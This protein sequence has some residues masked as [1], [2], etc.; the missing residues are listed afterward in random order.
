MSMTAEISSEEARRLASQCLGNSYDESI[1]RQFAA[2]LLPDAERLSDGHITGKYIPESFQDYVVSYRRLA[3]MPDAGK[4]KLDVLAVKLKNSSQLM[5]ARSMQRQFIARYLNG[6]RD[7]FKDA[8][9]VAFHSDDSP[10]WRFSFVYKDRVFI[11]GKVESVLSEP[12]RASFMVGPHELTH[13]AERQFVDLLQAQD[14]STISR[15]REAFGVERVTREFFNEYRQLFLEL[16]DII[17]QNIDDDVKVCKEF[18]SRDISAQ[19]YAKRMLG[20][21]VFLYFLQKKGW[22]GVGQKQKWS[23]GSH[24]FL[25]ELFT[26]NQKK[27]FFNDFLNPLFYDALATDRTSNDH[28]FALLGCRIPFL[29]G[30]LFEPLRGYD[31]RA[32]RLNVPN[33]FFE[34]LFEVFDRFNFTVREDEPLESEVAVDP[35][36]LG[37]V[38]EGLLDVEERREKGTFYTPRHIVHYMCRESLAQY[39][40]RALNLERVPIAD[41][42][43]FVRQDEAFEENGGK[44]KNRNKAAGYSAELSAELPESIKAHTKSIDDALADVKICDPAIGSGAFAVGMMHE[45]VRARMGLRIACPNAGLKSSTAYE[46][47]RN[48]IANSLYGVDLDPSAV[49][50]AK[51]RL[52]LSL[53]VDENDYDQIKPLPNLDYKIMA[54]NSLDAARSVK[55]KGNLLYHDACSQMEKLQKEFYDLTDHAQ[56]NKKREAIAVQREKCGNIGA[57]DWYIDFFNVAGNFDIVIGNPPYI[58]IQS[59]DDATK[60]LKPQYKSFERTGDIY[61]LFYELG[62][63]L[64]KRH[65]ILTF[66]T[67]NKWMRA[68]YG[69]SLRNFFLEYTK[70]IK[71]IDFA[72]NKVFDSATVDVNIMILEKEKSGEDISA[73]TIKENCSNNMSDYVE[74][75]SV[76]TRFEVGQSWAILSPI[77]QS[78]K[79]KIEAVGKPL[80]D[81]DV[82]IYRGI[83]TGCNEAFII[84]GT[85]KDELIAKDPK[86]AEII[87]PILRGRDIKRYGYNFADL[88][89]IATFPSRNYNIDKYPAV[90]EH[91]LSFGMERL[92]QSGKSY[93]INGK[94]VTARKKTNNKWF[95]TQ[96]SIGYWEDFNKQK[97]AWGNL[98]LEPQFALIEEGFFINAPAPLI[99]PGNEYLLSILNSKLTDFYLRTQG[100]SRNG[101]YFEYKPMFVEKMPIVEKNNLKFDTVY[102]N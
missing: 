44:T 10:D 39:L 49:D 21:I 80:K 30:G 24:A 51:L 67:S 86:S 17:Q 52:W 88:W 84:D 87:R 66:I 29:N 46:L 56:K 40:D 57:F 41:I 93:I 37:K 97:I 96:D 59:M 58:Q 100:V 32:L 63:T 3:K 20:Q 38:F 65:G 50:V 35:E 43:A 78:I 47:K 74:H 28:F 89:I 7:K 6:G 81:W 16:R 26:A 14:K 33:S 77:E 5:N 69:K 2:N 22:L 15:I 62:V 71:V 1:F 12:K 53:V 99:V 61:C 73:C 18:E 54:G 94:E 34:R 31:W 91:L 83:L 76:F 75:N 79:R 98:C 55:N 13:T 82:K 36:M 72:G 85:K 64:L 42:Q 19:V 23:T 92:E 45:I 60:A 4:E 27:D 25:K 102:I 9:L 68:A 101:G 8:A 95:E 11:D 48:T 90:K 70:P